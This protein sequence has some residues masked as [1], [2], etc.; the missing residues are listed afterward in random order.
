VCVALARTLMHTDATIVEIVCVYFLLK[1]G[2][3]YVQSFIERADRMVNDSHA[4]F[5]FNLSGACCTY[6]TDFA[7]V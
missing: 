6:Q 7:G 2:R 3:I 5:V 1:L 4:Y